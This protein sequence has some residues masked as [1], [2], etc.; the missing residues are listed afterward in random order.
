MNRQDQQLQVLLRGF[1]GEERRWQDTL[2]TLYEHQFKGYT[3]E[4]PEYQALL[5]ELVPCSWNCR[6]FGA[7]HQCEFVRICH[8]HEGWTDPIG[9]GHYQP[10][11]PHHDPELQ[12]AVARG[13]L[14]AEAATA[15]EE[16]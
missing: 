10:R 1:L 2:W 12:Q 16:E 11:L 8:R 14:P 13:L 15:E 7:E 3:W 9:S 5:D 6:P 4:S